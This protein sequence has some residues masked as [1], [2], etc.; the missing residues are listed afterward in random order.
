[1]DGMC[2]IYCS[3]EEAQIMASIDRDVLEYL[4]TDIKYTSAMEDILSK[5]YGY[6]IIS[7]EKEERY[8]TPSY[9]SD[10]DMTVLEAEALLYHLEMANAYPEAREYCREKIL[11]L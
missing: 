4:P 3:E 1:M 2:F 11:K 7:P 6:G 8:N 9:I 5:E 10:E